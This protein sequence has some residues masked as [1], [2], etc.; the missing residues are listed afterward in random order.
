MVLAKEAFK[1]RKL[2]PLLHFWFSCFI[3]QKCF[4]T[5]FSKGRHR[6]AKINHGNLILLPSFYLTRKT[7]G[8]EMTWDDISSGGKKTDPSFWQSL[9]IYPNLHQC[10]AL[11]TVFVHTISRKLSRTT[12]K[13]KHIALVIQHCRKNRQFLHLKEF[14]DFLGTVPGELGSQI[15]CGTVKSFTDQVDKNQNRKSHPVFY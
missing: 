8:N 15:C 14:T 9:G 10:Q 7:W 13:I 3:F 1:C 4:L 12:L 6:K 5:K 2:P 11:D